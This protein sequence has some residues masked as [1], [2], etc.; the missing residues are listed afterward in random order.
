MEYFIDM[1]SVIKSR[2][3]MCWWGGSLGQVFAAKSDNLSLIPGSSAVEGET[4]VSE[5]VL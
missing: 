2:E 3:N 4:Q 1:A 5:V